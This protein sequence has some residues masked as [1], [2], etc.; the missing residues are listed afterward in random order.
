MQIVLPVLRQGHFSVYVVNFLKH[1]VHIL[2]P[3]PWHLIG[4]GWQDTHKKQVTYG[5][6]KA[7]WCQHM[8][9]RLNRSIH[10]VRPFTT[11]PKFG[12]Y[13]IE[14]VEDRPA[15]EINS[16][17]CGPYICGFMQR[18]DAQTGKIEWD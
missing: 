16:H 10:E 7:Q 4:Q 3:N 5:G 1:K 18:Y 14:V 9:R 8:I 17:D 12:N 11:M 15:M 6:V 2:D 13:A